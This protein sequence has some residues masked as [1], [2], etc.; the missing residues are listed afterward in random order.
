M[1]FYKGHKLSTGRPKGSRNE[2]TLWLLERW[3]DELKRIFE[4]MKG[5]DINSEDYR[6]LVDAA[7]KAQKQI[8]L[9]SGGPTERNEIVG[10]EI[11]VL[12][13]G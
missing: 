8:Q 10:V 3:E 7:D 9:L 6:T 4:A 1:V 13:D 11:S 12:K 5:K 2:K